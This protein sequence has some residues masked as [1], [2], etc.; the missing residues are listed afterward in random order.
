M[1]NA[2]AL[3]PSL[4]YSKSLNDVIDGSAQGA[5]AQCS[6]GKN[7]TTCGANWSTTKW[8]GTQGLGQD[9]SALEAILATIPSAGVRTGNST[10][11]T[12]NTGGTQTG[13]S[14][15]SSSASPSGTNGA[16]KQGASMVLVVAA[17]LF[18]YLN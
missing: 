9:L 1:A 12:G 5:A 18:A 7:G 6:G 3:A 11:T 4:Q 17:L 15:T 13:G 8:D 14:Q 16:G 10:G 2:E